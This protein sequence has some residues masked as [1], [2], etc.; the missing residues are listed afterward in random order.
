M[1]SGKVDVS[2]VD[3]DDALEVLIFEQLAYGGE[4]D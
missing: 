2:L 3:D 1:F 4:G